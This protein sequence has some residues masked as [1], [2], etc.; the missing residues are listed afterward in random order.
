MSNEHIITISSGA[1]L[2]LDQAR[3]VIKIKEQKHYVAL[4]DIAIIILDSCHISISAAALADLASS[5]VIVIGCNSHH[6]PI[7]LTQPIG[8]NNQGAKRPHQQAYY[9]YSEQQAKWWAKLVTSKIIAQANNLHNWQSEVAKNLK[10]LSR[11]VILADKSNMEG[12]AARLYWQEFFRILN[13]KHGRIKQG[14]VDIVNSCL[15]YGYAILRAM[16]ARSLAGAGLCLSFGLGHMRKDNPFNLVED[17]ME[18]FRPY[19]DNIVMNILQIDVKNF[20]AEELNSNLK[21][22]IIEQILVL[23]VNL[24]NKNYRIFKAIDKIVYSYCQCLDNSRKVF[25]LPNIQEKVTVSEKTI[26]HMEHM[27]L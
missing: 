8:I 4:I 12:Q 14:A 25:I 19:I 26:F 20:E 5:G 22:Q 23:R 10:I 11:K 3:L 2:S 18:P 6:L 1:T 16:V 7:Y 9:L 21:K 24:S 17:F 27:Q 13:R 15:N